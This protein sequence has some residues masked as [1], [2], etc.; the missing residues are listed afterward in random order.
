M[1]VDQMLGQAE[2]E[3]GQPA[4]IKKDLDKD[5]FLQLLS[6]QLG[7]QDPLNPM[8]DKEFTAQLAQFS[9][10]EQMTNLNEGMDKLI[11]AEG[12][13]ELLGSVSFIGKEVLAK[14][15]DISKVGDYTSSVYYELDKPVSNMWVNVFDSW[16][17]LIRTDEIG[18]LSSG[19]FEYSWD[20]TDYQGR[21]VFD[22]L[23]KVSVAAEDENG[24]PVL[25]NT[26]VSGKVVGVNMEDGEKYLRM[27]D[28]RTA[29]LSDIK[30]VV[31]NNVFNNADN[32]VNPDE[33][34]P[35][36]Q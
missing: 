26:E 34:E 31:D 2:A 30:D 27:A 23:Y 24:K 28:G 10:L 22:G 25:V 5:A 8:E 16:G 4:K 33:S 21:Q 11:D 29:K 12:R 15:T 20:G 32:A 3:F 7:N 6:A 1:L 36:E 18:A 35:V 17:N 13:Q 19:S 14:G 9:Q